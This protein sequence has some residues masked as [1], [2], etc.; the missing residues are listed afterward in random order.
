MKLLT[1]TAAALVA[2][3]LATPAMAQTPQT[4]MIENDRSDNFGA[5][6]YVKPTVKWNA[7][8]NAWKVDYSVNINLATARAQAQALSESDLE[9]LDANISKYKKAGGP[10][11]QMRY[12]NTHIER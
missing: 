3:T 8:Y 7:T 1:M 5:A 9:K 6:I 10:W 4:G 2:M 11:Y 12:A